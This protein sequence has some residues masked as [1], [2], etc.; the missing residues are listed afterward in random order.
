MFIEGKRSEKLTSQALYV[1]GR[2]KNNIHVETRC[3]ILQT[4]N[5][6]V[7][8]VQYATKLTEYGATLKDPLILYDSEGFSDHTRLL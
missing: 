4:H 1:G 8:F 2:G 7:F 6:Q 5:G 3:G